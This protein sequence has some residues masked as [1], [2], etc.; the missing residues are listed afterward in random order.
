MCACICRVGLVPSACQQASRGA[1]YLGYLLANN[2]FLF[3]QRY[4]AGDVVS[5]GQTEIIFDLMKFDLSFIFFWNL[6]V[7]R[8]IDVTCPLIL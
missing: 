7:T 1:V 3:T 2:Y 8:K 6:L 5:L 4:R